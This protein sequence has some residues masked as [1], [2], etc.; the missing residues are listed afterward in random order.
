LNADIPAGTPAA[1]FN[2]GHHL[3]D[4]RIALATNSRFFVGIGQP[5]S[6]VPGII[7]A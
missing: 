3:L 2:F 6:E 7:G 5:L 1:R 4:A